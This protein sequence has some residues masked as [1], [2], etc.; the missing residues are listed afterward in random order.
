[1]Q[2]YVFEHQRIRLG[3]SLGDAGVLSDRRFANLCRLAVRNPGAFELGHRSI[4][5]THC[6]GLLQVPGLSLVVLP[7]LKRA[8]PDVTD[9]SWRLLLEHMVETVLRVRPQAPTVADTTDRRSRLM[10]IVAAQ[11]LDEVDR[12]RSRG[13]VRGYRDVEENRPVLRGRLLV[14]RN[15]RVNAAHAERFYVRHEVHDYDTAFNRVVAAALQMVTTLRV[16]GGLG[17]RARQVLQVLPEISQMRER[18]LERPLPRRAQHYE[19]ALDLARA[20]LRSRLPRPDAGK[21]PLFALLFDMN[22]LFED[23]VAL[24]MRR[25]GIRVRSQV[26]R[27]FLSLPRRM[28]KPDLVVEGEPPLVLD[29]KWKIPK[30]NKPSDADL[31]QMYVYDHVMG[32]ARAVLLYPATPES[33]RWRGAFFDQREVG[34]DFV[35]LLFDGRPDAGR[36]QQELVR[37]VNRHRD[38]ASRSKSSA[39]STSA[40]NPR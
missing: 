2:A 16:G 8:E 12:V 15:A 18:D 7:K 25:A 10:D 26:C 17:V 1:M 30:G 9:A 33:R 6:V 5:F 39:G 38:P 11:Y 35:P 31:K 20:L 4:R 22:A 32:A 24:L 23:Y 28:V 3:Q 13:L 37:L 36:V 27:P 19:R 14:S 34:I 21:R 29:T 40:K